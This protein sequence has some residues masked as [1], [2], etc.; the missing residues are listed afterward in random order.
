[1]NANIDM[2][3]QTYGAIAVVYAVHR[4]KTHTVCGFSNLAD[5]VAEA[6]RT[7]TKTYLGVTAEARSTQTAG[8]AG[9]E[10]V[11]AIAGG[12]DAGYLDRIV[13]MHLA[14]FG[15]VGVRAEGGASLR[16]ESI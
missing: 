5:N 3:E 8:V 1:M 2:R 11:L 9:A 13:R 4:D 15:L 14:S 10:L 12:F 16:A 7:F 6:M